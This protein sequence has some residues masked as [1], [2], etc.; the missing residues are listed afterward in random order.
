MDERVLQARV[1]IMVVS[2]MLLTII[3]TVLFGKFPTMVSQGKTLYARFPSAPGVMQGTPVRKSGILIGRVEGVKFIDSSSDVMVTIRTIPGVELYDNETARVTASLLG[4]AVVEFAPDP[5]KQDAKPLSNGSQMTGIVV[6]N[7]LE[8]FSK[9]EGDMRRSLNS[10]GSAGNEV[11]KLAQN[12]NK[13]IEGKDANKLDQVLN[14]TE[15]AMDS[16]HKAMANLNDLVGDEKVRADLKQ[17][18]A[19]V[20]KIMQETNKAVTGMQ[21]VVNRADKNLENLEHLTGPLGQ[22]GEQIAAKLDSSVTQLDQFMQQ[23]VTFT[24]KFSNSNQQGTLAKIMNDPE[25]YNQVLMAAKNVNEL[26]ARMRPVVEDARVFSDKIARDPG[27]LGLSGALKK[28]TGTKY[29]NFG[30]VPPPPMD[31][32]DPTNCAPLELVEPI[33]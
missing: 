30:N 23:L 9:M 27:Q 3:L 2:A 16:F 4:D 6:S 28:S 12:I 24:E 8:M 26:T 31:W 21:Q 15:L 18:L 7:P 1:G 13:L 5:G 14:K 20:P 29:P 33:K 17:S 10:V 19:D 25:L 11:S 22:R 32:R